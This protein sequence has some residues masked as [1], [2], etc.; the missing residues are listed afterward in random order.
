MQ[1]RREFLATTLAAIAA[2]LPARAGSPPWRAGL[3][4]NGFMSSA[5]EF[6]KTYP[7]WEVLDFAARLGFDGIE[8][9]EGWPQGGYPQANEIERVSALRGLYD[10]YGLKIY[11]FQTGGPG[12]H[13]AD[14]AARQAWL[15]DLDGKI[16]LAKALGC[17]FIG[18]WPGGGLEGHA[19]VDQ[20]ITALAGS[21]RE[22][23]KRCADN[24]LFLSF[25]IEPPF[26]FNTLD[27]L[28]TI[29]ERAGAPA[30]KTNYDPSHFDL[31][32]GSKGK[33][34]DMLRALGVDHIGHVHFTDTDGTLFGG[35]SRHLPAGEGHCDLTASLQLLREGGYTGWIMVDPWL[36]EDP[37][38]A[39]RQGKRLIDAN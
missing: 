22:A 31:M 32:S 2:A 29:L 10:R 38:R 24:G 1:N 13:S 5:A 9:V 3:G 8:L 20:A 14:P 4:L 11:T 6:K 28:H 25:E 17:D 33:P 36:I 26:I 27:H 19:D 7:L 39:A 23:A 35:T 12:A 30:L 16:A 15:A 18:H 37:Y 21:Y 34:E